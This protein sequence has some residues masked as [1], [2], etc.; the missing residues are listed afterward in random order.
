MGQE[1]TNPSTTIPKA[2]LTALGLTLIVYVVITVDTLLVL[3]PARLAASPAPLVDVVL[4]GSWSGAAAVVRI[5]AAAAALGAL[6]VLVAGIGR[7]TLALA[8]NR[9]LPT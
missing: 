7:T 9:K 8:R 5:S 2:I 3:G 1:V 4:G 6:F